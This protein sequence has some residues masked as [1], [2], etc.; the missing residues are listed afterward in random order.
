MTAILQSCTFHS[1]FIIHLVVLLCLPRLFVTINTL[2][3]VLGLVVD[4]FLEYE[5]IGFGRVKSFLYTIDSGW[6][7]L[8]T[9]YRIRSMHG[10]SGC[11]YLVIDFD[12]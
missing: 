7:Y 2:L 3:F 1:E 10:A 12:I 5:E 8:N 9:K 11:I 6:G 4:V